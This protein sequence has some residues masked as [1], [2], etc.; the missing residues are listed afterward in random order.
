MNGFFGE[1]ACVLSL[2]GM[3]HAYHR[4]VITHKCDHEQL[5]TYILGY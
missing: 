5:H 3:N 1:C 2:Q 4:A